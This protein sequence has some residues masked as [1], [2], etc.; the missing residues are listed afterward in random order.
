MR[1]DEW[2][3]ETD[4]QRVVEDLFIPSRR[5]RSMAWKFH[6]PFGNT[7]CNPACGPSVKLL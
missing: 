3:D 7:A 1:S 2:E 5:T 6:N 4:V